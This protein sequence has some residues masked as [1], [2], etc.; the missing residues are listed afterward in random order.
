M[1][2]RD[3]SQT[4]LATCRT[5]RS[6]PPGPDENARP[7]AWDLSRRRCPIGANVVRENVDRWASAAPGRL[8]TL[9]AHRPPF[10]AGSG[11]SDECGGSAP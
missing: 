2:P 6:A 11:L 7:T 4:V 8:P 1:N 5:L 3:L 10:D 9:G